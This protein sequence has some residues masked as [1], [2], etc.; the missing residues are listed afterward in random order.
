[1][2]DAI[3]RGPCLVACITA[4]ICDGNGDSGDGG[5]ARA[6]DSRLRDKNRREESDMIKDYNDTSSVKKEEV[7]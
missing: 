5:V 3:D 6:K 2:L 4:V 1:M 7:K